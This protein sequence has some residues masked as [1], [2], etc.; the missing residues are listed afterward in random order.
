MSEEI[1]DVRT[2]VFFRRF[3]FLKEHLSREEMK[4]MEINGRIKVFQALQN[5]YG[6]RKAFQLLREYRKYGIRFWDWDLIPK[7][8]HYIRVVFEQM[9]IR[10]RDRKYIVK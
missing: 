9:M 10:R 2:G 7:A 1:Y 8:F 3:T 5:G 4:Y 6:L